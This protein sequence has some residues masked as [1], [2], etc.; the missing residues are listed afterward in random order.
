MESYEKIGTIGEG[1]YGVVMKCRNRETGQVVAIKKFKESEDDAQIRKTALREVRMLKQLKH[2]NIVNLLEVFRRKGKLYLVFEHVDRTVLEDL[3]KH[4]HG[5]ADLRDRDGSVGN[6]VRRCMWQLLRAVE[7]LHSHSVI[8][9]DIKPENILI[10]VNG[11]VK[12]CDFGFARSLAGPGA[13]Y[14]DYVATRWYR[15]P[16]L[17]VGD[18]EYG[19]AVD[20]WATGC[21]LAELTNGQPLF[22]GDTDVDQLYRIVRCLGP[23][24]KRHLDVFMR[25]PMFVGVRVPDGG[26]G[27]N[28][29]TL[30]S[31]LAQL[32]PDALH[33]LH[34]C[35]QY[36]PDQRASAR[37][38]MSHSF[39]QGDGFADKFEN[40]L[41]RLFELEIEQNAADR[42]R[43]KRK[44]KQLYDPLAHR[45]LESRR[46]SRQPLE[47]LHNNKKQ[48]ENRASIPPIHNIPPYS[49]LNGFP[50]VNTTTPQ[51]PFST[52]QT[53]TLPI[54]Q[55]QPLIPSTL[56][57]TQNMNIPNQNM[58]P[59]V[60]L[61]QQQPIAPQQQQIQQQP[62]TTSHG[63]P[64]KKKNKNEYGFH[65][66]AY[67]QHPPATSH[68]ISNGVNG[69][70]NGGGVNNFL[71]RISQFNNNGPGPL[72]GTGVHGH[73]G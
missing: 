8:H 55:Q 37:Q 64:M 47:D 66:N 19:K 7:Y 38:L 5:L 34:C 42:Q 22:P 59:Q 45:A 62:P 27:S 40:E 65:G 51:L 25:N 70:N 61:L 6:A 63:Q 53:S 73:H 39:F 2:D 58:S 29:H 43:R 13:K 24:C 41:R 32:S 10:S 23:L 57:N 54:Q 12:L 18:V 31:R 36:D 15:A 3:D 16:E 17:L 28:K 20:I 44:T 67:G 33:W 71:P 50:A 1:T 46:E 9:R 4:P 48:E 56:P 11:V 21:I 60:S 72:I 26:M 49:R 52:Q 14:T 68:G 30:E 69:N 35:L